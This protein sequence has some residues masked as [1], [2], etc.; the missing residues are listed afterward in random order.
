MT[1]APTIIVIQAYQYYRLP[2][3]C[4]EKREQ[5]RKKIKACGSGS[6]MKKVRPTEGLRFL[7]SCQF[8]IFASSLVNLESID[9]W[10]N[11]KRT[12]E[13]VTHLKKAKK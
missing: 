9:S 3:L 1:V 5:I 10:T 4:Q 7:L 6:L 11:D 2:K 12:E 13:L 8:F